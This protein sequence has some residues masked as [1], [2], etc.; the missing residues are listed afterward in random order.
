VTHVIGAA[1]SSGEEPVGSSPFGCCIQ[2]VLLSCQP[3][4][5]QEGLVSRLGLAQRLEQTVLTLTAA[6]HNPGTSCPGRA[7][8][9]H[10]LLAES[11]GNPGHMG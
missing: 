3:T 9:V 4:L 11:G 5:T 8:G 1:E 2:E 10:G 7:Q 6:T